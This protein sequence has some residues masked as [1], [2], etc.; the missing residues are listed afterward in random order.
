MKLLMARPAGSFA[1]ALLTLT[2][3]GTSAL[4]QTTEPVAC[5]EPDLEVRGIHQ[6]CAA[7][8]P[9]PEAPTSAER[10]LDVCLA[11]RLEALRARC[12]TPWVQF[13]LGV[14]EAN[15]GHW[16]RAWTLL[17]GALGERDPRVERARAWV[18][19]EVLP[20]VRQNVV[21]IEPRCDAPDASL[22]V[23]GARVGALPLERPWVVEPGVVRVR[24]TARGHHDVTY[25]LVA[26]GGG[27]FGDEVVLRRRV[28][29]PSSSA[30]TSPWFVGA[31]VGALGVSAGLFVM[32]FDQ[33]QTRDH[34]CNV[35]NCAN[36]AGAQAAQELALQLRVGAF[37]ALGVG[38]AAVVSGTAWWLIARPDRAPRPA[39]ATVFVQPEPSGLQIVFGGN[40]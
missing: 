32:M 33:S 37:A 23:D 35:D 9:T 2:F 8:N 26:G 14:S 28:V 30:S 36:P 15:L 27:R 21:L 38:A 20:K 17:Q 31:G 4:A 11:S 6:E 3:S 34:L 25:T 39:L 12:A 10:R 19:R 7:A 22:E 40:L 1:A 18:E 16:R 5:A 24:V 13:N 29:A